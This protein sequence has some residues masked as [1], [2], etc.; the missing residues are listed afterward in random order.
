MTVT[1]DCTLQFTGL[2]EIL[3]PTGLTSIRWVAHGDDYST[4][5]DHRLKFICAIGAITQDKPKSPLTILKTKSGGYSAF[6]ETFGKRFK[7]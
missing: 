5:H 7:I 4:Q 3:L 2:Y 1:A 6:L